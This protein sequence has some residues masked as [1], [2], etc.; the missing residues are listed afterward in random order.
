MVKSQPNL[1]RKFSHSIHVSRGYASLKLT[2]NQA[3]ISDDV[4]QIFNCVFHVSFSTAKLRH[5]YPANLPKCHPAFRRSYRPQLVSV[6]IRSFRGLS[7]WT[8]FPLTCLR[9]LRFFSLCFLFQP[10]IFSSVCHVSLSTAK[11]PY[12]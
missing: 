12:K 10:M 9:N 8:S 11:P 2:P 6:L 4:L 5:P 1:F 3:G 7:F